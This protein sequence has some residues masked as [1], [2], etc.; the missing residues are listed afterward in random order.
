MHRAN[1]AGKIA[2]GKLSTSHAPASLNQ[3]GRETAS[4]G[5]VNVDGDP[6]TGPKRTGLEDE[7]SRV[8]SL[9]DEILALGAVDSGPG[10]VDDPR[11]I[12]VAG[13]PDRHR[14]P[15][16]RHAPLSSRGVPAKNGMIAISLFTTP[17]ARPFPEDRPL[18]AVTNAIPDGTVRA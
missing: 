7:R 17:C 12:K 4:P 1:V 10:V 13:Q 18:H 16:D 15:C 2:Y 3:P 8:D 5:M 9:L 11:V 14:G 6:F